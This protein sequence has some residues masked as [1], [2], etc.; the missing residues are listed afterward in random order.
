MLM[1]IVLVITFTITT[2]IELLPVVVV[3]DESIAETFIMTMR[4]ITITML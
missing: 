4:V 1:L 3:L 2:V